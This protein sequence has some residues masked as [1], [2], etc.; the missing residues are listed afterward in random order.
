[1][2]SVGG[3]VKGP[4]EIPPG[5]VCHRLQVRWQCRP[6]WP[7]AREVFWEVSGRI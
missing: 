7:D 3:E 5:V 4:V 6:L 1:M 2:L